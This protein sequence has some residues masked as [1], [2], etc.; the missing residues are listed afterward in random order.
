MHTC[1]GCSTRG[2]VRRY[3]SIC[4]Y[5]F[6]VLNTIQ[7]TCGLNIDWEQ[8]QPTPA[9]TKVIGG[10]VFGAMVLVTIWLAASVWRGRRIGW[11]LSLIVLYVA[12]F[13]FSIVLEFGLEGTD[14]GPPWFIAV[15]ILVLLTLLASL[16][17]L[18][19]ALVQ[20]TRM[21][22]DATEASEESLD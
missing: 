18:V 14:L 11:A 8:A 16:V 20:E 4:M 13:G 19:M 5:T 15:R 2:S 22:S 3:A 12:S 9:I 17:T 1:Y 10:I 7:V 21:S 6:A